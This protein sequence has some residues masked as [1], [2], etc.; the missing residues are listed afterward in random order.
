[1]K[2]LN[3]NRMSLVLIGFVAV[4]V[5]GGENAKADFT[6]GETTNL[7]PVVNSQHDEQHPSISGDGLELYFMSRRPGGVG[8]WDIWVA[9][10]ETIHDPWTEPTNAGPTVNSSGEDWAPCISADGLELYFEANRPGGYGDTDIL[11][12]SR[13]MIDEPWGYPVNL[14][15]TLN[16]S[17]RDGGPSISSDGLELYFKSTRPGGY[18][19]EDLWVTKRPAKDEP[20]GN[21]VHLGPTINSHDWERAPSISADGLAFFFVYLNAARGWGWDM[22]LT[23]RKTKNIAWGKPVNL[24]P[25]V[26]TPYHEDGPSVSADGRTLY[27]CYY[28]V[29]TPRPGGYG[30]ADLWQATISPIVDFNADGFVDSAD[31]CIMVDHWGTDNSLCDIGPMP[32]GDGIVDVQDLIV[33]AEHLFEDVNN[34][35]LIAHWPLDEAQGDIAYDSAGTSDGTLVGVPVWQPAGGIVDGA[36][37]LDGIDDYVSTPFVLNPADGKFSVFA[38]IKGGAPGQA[39]LSQAGGANWL[40]TD[41]LEGNLITELKELGRGAAIL[42]SHTVITDGNWHRIGLV[43]DGSNRTLY[44]DDVEVAK[45]TQANLGGPDN[46]LYIGAGTA[47][48]PGS[49]WSGLIDDVR[50]YNRAVIP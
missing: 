40:C 14:G 3:G 46:G 6:F 9:R 36:L 42:T 26:N 31:M 4:I 15:P 38:W 28:Y 24:G 10:R 37:Q 49:F 30:G 21:P 33:L 47:M 43:W 45:D 41:S 12:A 39:V 25:S 5:I 27:F 2:W 50:I 22:C 13:K 20:W 23:S 11:V 44:V 29:G 17:S 35:T 19:S 16:S 8:D 32:W 34:P 48:E 18:G 1:M 7:G